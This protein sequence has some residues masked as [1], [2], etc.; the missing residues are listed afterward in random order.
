V[1]TWLVGTRNRGKLVELL[2]LLEPYHVTAITL[3]DAGVLHSPEE[4]DIEVFTTFEENAR[5]KAVYYAARSGLPC[6]ADDSGLCVDALDG[7]P[8][9]RSRRFSH[10][11]GFTARAGVSEDAMNNE[12]LVEACWDS[13]RAPPWSASFVCAMALADSSASHVASA[14]TNGEIL[15]DAAGSGGFGYDP[16]FL[17]HDL[18]KT[19]AL[20]SLQEKS[21]ISHRARALAALLARLGLAR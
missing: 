19:F 17:S 11:Q 7:A 9:V 15:P 1:H 4:D 12:A 3:D 10:D 14:R 18:Q 20:A 16:L 21:A 2:P 8:G 13:G 6:L 5:A